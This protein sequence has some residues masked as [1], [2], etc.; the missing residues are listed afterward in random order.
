MSMVFAKTTLLRIFI[1]AFIARATLQVM[2][3]L[4]DMSM[5]SLKK[6]LC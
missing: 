3:K 2:R 5:K 4:N 1:L 6:D